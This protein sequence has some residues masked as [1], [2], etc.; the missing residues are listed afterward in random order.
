MSKSRFKDLYFSREYFYALGID[1]DT[2][3]H[4]LAIPVDNGRITYEERYRIDQATF[5]RYLAD[6]QAAI[7][8]AQRCRDRQADDA[9]FYQ[10]SKIR[11]E[12]MRPAH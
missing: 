1:E 3:W 10:P 4:Y 11:G 6:P 9:L 12:P 7:G 2:G 8:F 5:D